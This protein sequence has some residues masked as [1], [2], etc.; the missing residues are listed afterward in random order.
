MKVT[1]NARALVDT[2]FEPDLKLLCDLKHTVVVKKPSQKKR[3]SEIHNAT[4]HRVI[5]QGGRITI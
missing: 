2:R 3:S 5:H 4:N 1:R